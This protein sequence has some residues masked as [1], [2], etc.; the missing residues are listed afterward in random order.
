MPAG[1]CT[2]LVARR[3]S[4]VHFIQVG[5]RT[6]GIFVQNAMSNS[7]RPVRAQISGAIS[8]TDA[9]TGSRVIIRG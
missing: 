7:A 1:T 4:V 8:L 5:E 6:P 9:N 2:D 3:G